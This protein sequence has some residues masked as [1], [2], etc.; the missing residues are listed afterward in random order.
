MVA[1]PLLVLV[2]ALVLGVPIAVALA[3]SGM[4]G[5]YLVT[6]D[7][8]KGMGILS[9]AAVRTVAD[10]ALTTIPMFILMAFSSASSG[11]ARDLYTAAANWC[12]H[13][14]GGLAIATGVARGI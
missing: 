1:F 7:F 3:A 13:V 6:G 4:L 5:I 2:L 11:L 9:P 10:Y 8:G 14:R 12:S